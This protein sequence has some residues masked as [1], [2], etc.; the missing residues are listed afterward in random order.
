MSLNVS[1]N[2]RQGGVFLVSIIGSIDSDTY[3]ILDEKTAPILIPETKVIIFDMEKVEYI[4]SMG[5]NIIF[6]TQRAVEKN[7]G[8]FVMT[9]I[10]P[11]VKK[12]LEV[13]KALP[14]MKVFESVEEADSYLFKIQRD[15][16]EK[17]RTA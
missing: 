15:E 11:Q 8:T 4:S 9:D 7:G 3:R 12:V 6:K 5:L 2:K 14:N 13:V 17:N 16:I 1:V 10:Q